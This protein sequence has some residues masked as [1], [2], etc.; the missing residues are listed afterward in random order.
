MKTWHKSIIGVGALA[1][2]GAIAWASVYEANKDV[3]TVQTGTVVREDLRTLVS[4]SGEVR[5]NNYTNVVGQGVGII[6]SIDVHEGDYVKKGDVLLHVDNVQPAADVKAQQASIDSFGAAVD[7]ADANYNASAAT[8]TQRQSDLDKA[9]LDWDREQ[10]MFK[11]Q[12]VA[13]SDYDATK[14][15]YDSAVGA[16]AAAKAQVNQM[17]AARDQS[18][19]N[20]AQAQ[21]TMVHE[22]DILHKTTYF[23]PIS[24]LVS[25]IA[26]RVGENVVPGIQNSQGSFLLTLSDMSVVTA[27]VKVDE[28]DITNVHNGE[29]AE[30]TIDAIP[31]KTFTGKVTAVGDEAILRTSGDASMTETTADTQNARD[32]KVV[33]TLD[34][35][36]ANL[37]PGLSVTAKIETAKKSDVLGIP[38]Q[39]LAMRSQKDLQAKQDTGSSVTLAASNSDATPASKADVQG[40]F[41]IRGA[42]VQFVPVQ[43]GISGVTDIEVT[44]GLQLGDQIVIGSYKALRS[45]QSGAA[46][47]ID[48]TITS[49]TDSSS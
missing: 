27:E 34:H 25:Y 45:L 48:N 10:A 5:P 43:T 18:K 6:T 40:V 24:G 20:L 31:N 15:T 28:T 29:P 44:G 17:A 16:L 33:V 39:A 19:S 42:K 2:L 21:A 32:F 12:L 35:P 11:D 7:A 46:I 30:V 1:A 8:V 37:R 9:K 23:A 41:V 26:V 3:V 13:Q 14:A 47:K 22:A 49:T 38:I 36:P 4:G